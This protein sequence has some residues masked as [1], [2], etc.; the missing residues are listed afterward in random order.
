MTS[1]PVEGKD[2]ICGKG[3]VGSL[4]TR[5]AQRTH[6]EAPSRAALKTGTHSEKCVLKRF[7]CWQR[8]QR[9]LT[10]TYMLLAYRTPALDG[11][12]YYSQATGL[13]RVLLHKTA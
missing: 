10:Q 5:Q 7:H 2:G 3:L 13:R 12:A 9:A 1:G 6:N 4:C 8:S 11:T